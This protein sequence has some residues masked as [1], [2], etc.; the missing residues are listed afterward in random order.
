LDKSTIKVYL[1]HSKRYSYL[2]IIFTCSLS[3]RKNANHLLTSVLC[4]VD[5]EQSLGT[6]TTGFSPFCTLDWGSPIK[7]AERTKS[8]LI[9]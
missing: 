1:T 4:F 6:S 5:R 7:G 9:K 3:C 8:G 2:Q